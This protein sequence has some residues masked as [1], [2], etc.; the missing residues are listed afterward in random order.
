M[1]QISVNDFQKLHKALIAKFTRDA[2]L[3]IVIG[4]AVFTVAGGLL[5]W[6]YDSFF[7]GAVIGC[8]IH[9]ALIVI[10][11]DSIERFIKESSEEA[12]VGFKRRVLTAPKII[13][14]KYLQCIKE[15]DAEET[16]RWAKSNFAIVIKPEEL[17]QMFND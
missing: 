8:G 9:A 4:F 7:Y 5:G 2:M 10:G 11:N 3:Q 15:Y 17:V 1:I 13:Q 12:A 16:K 14:Q 6:F